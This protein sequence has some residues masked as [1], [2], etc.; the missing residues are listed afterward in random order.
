[1][2]GMN[3][4][5]ELE[6]LNLAV[7]SVQKIEGLKRCESLNKLDFTLN[8][9]DIE[10]LR[11]SLENLEWN[12]FLTDMYLTGNP[13]TDWAHYREYTIAKVTTLMNLDGTEISK[14][15]RLIAKQKLE[16]MEYELDIVSE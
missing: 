11:E 9:I 7:N 8:F 16:K 15:E 2:E 5:K 12:G 14:S 13:C 4:L 6:Y 1:M 3:K 10:N